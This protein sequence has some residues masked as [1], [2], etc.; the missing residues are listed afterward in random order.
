MKTVEELLN[1]KFQCIDNR[2]KSRIVDFCTI[3][4]LKEIGVTLIPEYEKEHK[5][6]PMTKEVVIEQLRHDT[7]FGQEKALNE[8]GIS[9][10]QMYS[11]VRM[12]LWILEDPL[13]DVYTDDTYHNYGLELFE[14]VIE[15]YVFKEEE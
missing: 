10:S 14:R 13:Y 12:W 5:V 4:Q 7:L 6:I 2:D 9:S 8:R 11:V 1:Y 15:E 3:P